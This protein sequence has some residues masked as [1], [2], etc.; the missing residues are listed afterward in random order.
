MRKQGERIKS[1][2][3]TLI[4][5][6][7]LKKFA[8]IVIGLILVGVAIIFIVIGIE[9]SAKKDKQRKI[10]QEKE[11]NYRAYKV[12]N[13]ELRLCKN[14]IIKKYPKKKF[15]EFKYSDFWA[16]KNQKTYTKF[17]KQ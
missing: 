14:K 2:T 4:N 13:D 17:E 15:V 3:G 9:H 10:Q 11:T 7:G 12:Y 16:P 5:T 8:K 1:K 6:K